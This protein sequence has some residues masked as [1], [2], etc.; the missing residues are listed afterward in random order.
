MTDRPPAPPPAA[1]PA[2]LDPDRPPGPSDLVVRLDP[3]QRARL[4]RDAAAS[5]LAP[6]AYVRARAAAP[7]TNVPAW[8]AAYRAVLAAAAAAPDEAPAA[9]G[10][11]R[12]EFEAIAATVFE[13]PDDGLDDGPGTGAG[14]SASA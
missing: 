13:A 11:L 1:P 9:L 3:D 8:R 10:A 14:P 4:D 7:D 6:A 2:A 5:G 12:V